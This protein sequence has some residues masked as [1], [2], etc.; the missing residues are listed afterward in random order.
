MR[1]LRSGDGIPFIVAFL[2]VTL[3]VAGLLVQQAH[4]AFVSHRVTAESVLR[5]YAALAAAEAVRRITAEVDFYG[6]YVVLNA[7]RARAARGGLEAG[8]LD[9]LRRDGDERV[10]RAAGLAEDLIVSEGT[11]LRALGGGGGEALGLLRPQL[12]AAQRKAR[13]SQAQLAVSL[14]E[15]GRRREYVFGRLDD[16][17]LVGFEVSLP[18]LSEWITRALGREPLLPPS[19]GQGRVENASLFMR[20]ED[21][22][23][24]ERYRTEKPRV[25]GLLARVGFGDAHGG[26]MEGWTVETAID[27]AAA[28]LLVI[29]GLPRSRLPVLLALLGVAAGLLFA[30]ALLLR[31]ER[32][33]QRLRADF[34][35]GVSH[36]L[37]T[38]LTQIR[39][40]A[41]TLLLGRVRSEEERLRAL[42]IIDREARRLTHLVENVLQ[43]SRGEQGALNLLLQERELA[44]LVAEAVE[45][46]GLLAPGVDFETRLE[47]GVRARV[48]EDALRQVLLNLLDNAVK[49]GPRKQ[50]VRVGLS[51]DGGRV[52]LF[53]EDEG[54]GIPAA[55][56]ARVFERFRRLDRDRRSAVAGA[57]IGLAVVR[58]LV[59][60]HGG[61][62][63]VE[64][65][66][67][68]ARLVVELPGSG[69]P[70]EAAVTTAAAAEP[71]A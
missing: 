16:G 54:P 51:V 4:Y 52:R 49:Y 64:D 13:P 68:G 40:F 37:R 69:S 28:P 15:G 48:D 61:R 63:F 25:G 19:L 70:A 9:A 59:E 67:R 17:R 42:R 8:T 22:G 55:D 41:E 32:A 10:R 46:F 5:D 21:P 60:R 65:G 1:A 18:T 47:D 34:I 14:Q 6:Y 45:S 39:M 62:A 58:E 35:T 12:E 33:L 53:V 44:P 56:R 27:P 31:R 36:E 7:L 24:V 29:G 2:L 43:F 50:V 71:E 26:I 23:G 20:I 30:A 38:P 11:D 3:L 57:G 66:A